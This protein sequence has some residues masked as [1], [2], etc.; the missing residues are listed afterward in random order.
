MGNICTNDDF[1]TI[2]G[3]VKLIYNTLLVAVPIILLL[4]GTI[5]LLKAVSSGDE[6]A[7]KAATSMLGK[8]AMAAAAVFLFIMVVRL[9]TGILGNQDWKD[10]WKAGKTITI[11]GQSNG[12]E[13][14]NP[15]GEDD[16]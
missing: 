15:G 14:N 1:S 5:D 4:M 12:G 9:L 16:I 7:V 2:I 11:E 3:Y 6:K 13:N 8:R 10:C